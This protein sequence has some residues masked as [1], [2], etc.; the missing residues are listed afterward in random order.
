M[1][2]ITCPAN[3]DDVAA[4]WTGAL[5]DEDKTRIQTWLE[6][7]WL[8]VK[9]VPAL[10]ER[11]AAERAPYLPEVRCGDLEQEAIAVLCSMVIRV[12]KNPKSLW[13]FGVDDGSAQYDRTISSGEIYLADDERARLAPPQVNALAGMYS[14]PMGLPYWGE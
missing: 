3:A 12:L 10:T 8:Q 14:I 1:D 9:K 7:A 5:T 11:I 13:A 6:D 2:T 4:R